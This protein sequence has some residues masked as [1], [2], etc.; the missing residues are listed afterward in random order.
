M[1]VDLKMKS[2]A[3]RHAMSV[4]RGHRDRVI[5]RNGGDRERAGFSWIQDPL[6]IEGLQQVVTSVL[7]YVVFV[8]VGRKQHAAVIDQRA[9]VC[10]QYVI[11][12]PDAV[13]TY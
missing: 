11:I 4:G 7:K 5:R 1:V 10:I 3:D 12:D 6:R 2:L 8:V 9:A 13:R